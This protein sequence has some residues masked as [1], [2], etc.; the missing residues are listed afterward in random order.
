[1]ETSKG[2]IFIQS[3]E[4]S[5]Y[6]TALVLGT[7]KYLKNGNINLYFQNRINRTIRLYKSGNILRIIV[8]GDNGAKH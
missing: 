7:S 4:F 5:G 1:M 2:K 6:K 8:S 3:S